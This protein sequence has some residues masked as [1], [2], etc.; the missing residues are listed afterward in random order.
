MKDGYA[1]MFFDGIGFISIG[2]LLLYAPLGASVSFV[3][4]GCL[5]IAMSWFSGD[6]FFLSGGD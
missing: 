3:I 5:S 4:S 2:V 6:G 1:R